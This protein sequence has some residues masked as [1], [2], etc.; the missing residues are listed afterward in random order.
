MYDRY[1]LA[2]ALK[3]YSCTNQGKLFA[4]LEV[5]ILRKSCPNETSF[6]LTEYEVNEISLQWT[7]FVVSV[8]WSSYLLDVAL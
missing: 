6:L 3:I 4:G 8:L 1:Q 7:W 2:W 5:A